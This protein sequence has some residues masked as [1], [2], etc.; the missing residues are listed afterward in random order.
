MNHYFYFVFVFVFAFSFRFSFRSILY[1]MH[2]SGFLYD[3]LFSIYL[4]ITRK[5]VKWLGTGQRITTCQC[6]VDRF[7]GSRQV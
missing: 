5:K 7:F 6:G 4:F 1:Y 2:F 3:F